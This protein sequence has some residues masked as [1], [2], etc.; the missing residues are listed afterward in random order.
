MT[1]SI[2]EE[3]AANNPAIVNYDHETAWDLNSRFWWLSHDRQTLM[4]KLAVAIQKNTFLR[5]LTLS[6]N[7]A[8]KE[9]W[10]QFGQ[11]VAESHVEEVCIDG[12]SDREALAVLLPALSSSRR[13]KKFYINLPS[14]VD[15]SIWFALTTLIAST[16]NL[17][18]LRL[19]CWSPQ[20]LHETAKDELALAFACAKNLQTIHMGQCCAAL[21]DAVL[22]ALPSDRSIT[23]LTIPG[24]ETATTSS[25][26]EDYLRRSELGCLNITG[27]SR[28]LP[29]ANSFQDYQS[30][31]QV[32]LLCNGVSPIEL[33]QF[34]TALKACRRL[35]ELKV[36]SAAFDLVPVLQAL[37]GHPIKILDIRVSHH[38]DETR[39]EGVIRDMLLVPACQL[40]KL[41]LRSFTLS[42]IVA[43]G[44]VGN[45]SLRELEISHCSGDVGQCLEAAVSSSTHIQRLVYDGPPLSLSLYDKFDLSHCQD[46][47]LRGTYTS[48]EAIKDMMTAF[49]PTQ[50]RR[51]LLGSIR[52]EAVSTLAKCLPSLNVL[53]FACTFYSLDQKEFDKLREG[54]AANQVLVELNFRVS[55][56]IRG[57]SLSHAWVKEL[58]PFLYRNRV[59]SLSRSIIHE[60]AVLPLFTEPL[61]T[62]NRETECFGVYRMCLPSLL[63]GIVKESM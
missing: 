27:V 32:N 33:E 50:I 9:V 60:N 28:F 37:V 1:M 63:A 13:L 53:Q 12:G 3:L 4:P 47:D 11:A 29:L 5:K 26:L 54:V 30:L 56:G 7:D 44:L 55:D 41:C 59:S 17:Q 23:S 10:Y 52:S 48:R 61:S 39:I 43:H 62:T 20:S 51:L 25:C 6:V 21:Q 34:P 58:W 14:P 19:S 42:N 2:I 57:R 24:F 22:F 8:P 18:V 40:E 16:E 15:V 36:S 31:S 49:C 38:Q 45:S 35:S 46:I